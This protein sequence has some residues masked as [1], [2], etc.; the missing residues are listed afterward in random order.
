MRILNKIMLVGLLFLLAVNSQAASNIRLVESSVI[1]IYTTF[2]SP[3]YLSPWQLSNPMQA[4]GSGTV[5]SENRIL[6]NAHVVANAKYI[7]AQKHNDP[8]KYI[9]EVSFISHYADLAILTIKDK[10][11]FNGLKALDVGALPEP[12]QEVA[13]FGYPMGGDA[14]SI[15]QGV[16]SRVEQQFYSH[17]DSHLLAG[18]IDAAINPG[19]SGGPVVVNNKIVGVVMQGIPSAIASNVGYFIPPSIIRHVLEDSKDGKNDGFP[20]LGFRTQK[21]ENPSAKEALGLKKGQNGI[22]VIKVFEN[23]AAANK[24]KKNDVILKI[25]NY[26]IAGN[27]T[28]NFTET[29]RS[30]YEHAIELHHI[31]D[32]VEITFV[33]DGKVQKTSLIAQKSE[34][35]HDLVGQLKYEHTPEY[36]IYGGVVFM[37]LNMNMLRLRG[38]PRMPAS[39]FPYLNNESQWSTADRK[40]LVIASQVLAADVNLGYHNI[41]SWIIDSVNGTA[42]KDF[43]HFYQLLKNNKEKYVNFEDEH[44]YQM[45][46]NHQEAVD[47]EKEVLKLYSIPA[48]HSVGL[49][50]NKKDLSTTN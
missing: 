20:E 46:L 27:G 36:Y 38:F 11:F 47:S 21:L 26:S 24:L 1:K 18:Q 5:I 17:S 48:I 45:I 15:T 2:V 3:N 37:P 25:D 13:V 22:L 7:Q 16:L 40:E 42:I 32:K 4:S 29:L 35:R 30:H 12:H 43:T 23:S 39:S 34:K 9:A 28:I 8:R 10:T 6:T 31:G 19:N 14:L 50:D 33:R 49:F 41:N 44:G